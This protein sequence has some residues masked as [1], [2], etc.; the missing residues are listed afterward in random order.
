MFWNKKRRNILIYMLSWVFALSGFFLLNNVFGKDLMEQAFESAMS[1]DTVI[2]IG[3]TKEAV[4]NNVLR[5]SMTLWIWDSVFRKAC[6]VNE[7]IKVGVTENKCIEMAGERRT[8]RID[9]DVKVPLIVRITKFLL[10]MTIV[11][12]ITMVIFTA[13]KYMIEVL[14]GKDRKS[15]DSKKNLILIVGWVVLSL[16]SV[17]IINLIVS[18]PKSSL[19]T[20]D[21]LSAFEIWCKTWSTIVVGNDLKKWICEKSL[22][23]HPSYTMPYR[24]RN[25]NKV[26]NRCR[27]ADDNAFEENGNIKPWKNP[28]QGKNR[29]GERKAITNSEMKT[30]CVED[31]WWSVVQ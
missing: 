5:E 3:N 2:K 29:A 23:G 28:S 14:W 30:K 19:N 10:R 25:P 12:S 16:M 22:F 11:L 15:A 1:Y 26:W 13:V 6:F 4:W 20:S 31:M 8:D 7:Q 21:D 9:Y 27:F 18:V 24:Y 17:S